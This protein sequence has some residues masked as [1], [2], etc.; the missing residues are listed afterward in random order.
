MGPVPTNYY[1]EVKPAKPITYDEKYCWRCHCDMDR[2]RAERLFERFLK[3][4]KIKTYYCLRCK[5]NR[6]RF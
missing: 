4:L 1:P 6:Y 3:H 5:T 2:H